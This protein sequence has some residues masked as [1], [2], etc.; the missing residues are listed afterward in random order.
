VIRSIATHWKG[1]TFGTRDF[2]EWCFGLMGKDLT[3]LTDEIS[4]DIIS[5]PVLYAR[6]PEVLLYLSEC[7]ISAQVTS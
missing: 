6:L 1:L 3:L 7:L 5:N 2:V 4:F